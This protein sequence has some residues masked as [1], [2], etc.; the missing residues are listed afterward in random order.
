MVTSFRFIHN[1]IDKDQHINHTIHG[2]RT[3]RVQLPAVV[4]QICLGIFWRF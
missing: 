2:T 4:F 1:D 3:T